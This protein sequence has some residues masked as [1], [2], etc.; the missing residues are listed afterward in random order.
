[1]FVFPRNWSHLV[2]PHFWLFK[3][4]SFIQLTR[5]GKRE[6]ENKT[7]SSLTKTVLAQTLWQYLF[8][9]V[10]SCSRG[11]KVQADYHPSFFISLYQHSFKPCRNSRKPFIL[12]FVFVYFSQFL[13]VCESIAVCHADR[14]RK[15]LDEASN[16]ERKS[17]KK[18]E[19]GIV[20]NILWAL[21]SHKFFFFLCARTKPHTHTLTHTG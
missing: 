1:M 16:E 18:R 15:S 21:F 5:I 13:C 3:S 7:E 11:T 8:F 19:R 4:L 17:R 2:S 12:C 14:S 10:T 6:R 9:C 20:R